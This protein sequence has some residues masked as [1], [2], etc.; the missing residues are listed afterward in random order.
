MYPQPYPAMR[1]VK[2]SAGHGR[3]LRSVVQLNLCACYGWILTYR[4]T[5]EATS[6]PVPLSQCDPAG[7]ALQVIQLFLGDFQDNSSGRWRTI[8]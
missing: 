1:F 5:N 2:V 6:S 8:I 7:P 3:S 4:K